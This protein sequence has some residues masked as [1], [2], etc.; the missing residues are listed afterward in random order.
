MDWRVFWATFS[1]I[2]IAELGDKTQLATISMVSETKFPISVFIGAIAAF[3]AATLVA[4]L[5]GSVIS[6]Y[7]PEN[8]IRIGAGCLFLV[9]GLLTLTGILK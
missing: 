5:I 6:K 1:M 4:F 2:F 8:Y 7:V 9:I 3:F